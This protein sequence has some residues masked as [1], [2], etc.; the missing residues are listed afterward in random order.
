MGERERAVSTAGFDG[1]GGEG[2]G[3]EED[4][5]DDA[6]LEYTVMSDEEEALETRRFGGMV[7]EGMR[8]W[9]AGGGEGKKV[10]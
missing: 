4:A 5:Y 3:E 8:G 2:E 10:G 6:S 9:R 1:G 7:G